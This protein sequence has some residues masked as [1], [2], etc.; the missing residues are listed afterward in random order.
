MYCFQVTPTFNRSASAFGFTLD[1]LIIHKMSKY[2]LY[3]I[4]GSKVKPNPEAE[5][6]KVGIT[7]ITPTS[8]IITVLTVTA[9]ITDI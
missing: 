4:R 6:L 2:A 3:K 7:I 1:P 9:T 8:I 5:R